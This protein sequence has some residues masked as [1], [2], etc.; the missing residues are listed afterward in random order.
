MRRDRSG[1]TVLRGSTLVSTPFT[2]V[3]LVCL[4]VCAYSV[5]WSVA[6]APAP[7]TG[8]WWTAAASGAVGLLALGAARGCRVVLEDDHVRDQVAFITVWSG[9]VSGVRTVRVRRG[10]WRTFELELLDG[11]RRVLLGVGPVQFPSSLQP[12]ARERDMCTIDRL[13]LRMG[14]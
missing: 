1:R 8:G 13:G 7:T 11:T 6:S 9:K 12:D 2:L 10:P 3:G 14:A 4:A 5:T